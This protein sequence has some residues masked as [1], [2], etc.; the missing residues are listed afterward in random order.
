MKLDEAKLNAWVD[1]HNTPMLRQIARKIVDNIQYISNE[2]YQAQLKTMHEDFHAKIGNDA[3]VT[4]WDGVNEK[5]KPKNALKVSELPVHLLEN[6]NIKHVLVLGRKAGFN[7]LA[8]IDFFW[9]LNS[10]TREKLKFYIGVPYLTRDVANRLQDLKMQVLKYEPL[11]LLMDC[12]TLKEKTY[13]QTLHSPHFSSALT[14]SYFEDNFPDDKCT[15]QPIM[16]GETLAE[17]VVEEQ[18]AV[19][20]AGNLGWFGQAVKGELGGNEWSCVLS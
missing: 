13:I 7:A 16:T 14:L 4:L 20:G 5:N 17:I 19:Q 8:L 6:P 2:A 9:K 18:Q 12:F 11:L 10:G 15:F 3:F 1:A